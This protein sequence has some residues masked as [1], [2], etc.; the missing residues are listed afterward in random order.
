MIT[1]VRGSSSPLR[2]RSVLPRLAGAAA[3]SLTAMAALTPAAAADPVPVAP[4]RGLAIQPRTAANGPDLVLDVEG[5]TTENGAR[6]RLQRYTGADD[7]LWLA[8]PVGGELFEI[9]NVH[10]HACLDVRNNSNADEAELIQYGC[11]SGANQRWKAVAVQGGGFRI[12][13][14]GSGKCMDGY[15]TASDEPVEGAKVVQTTCASPVP[16]DQRWTFVPV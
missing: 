9:R 16:N 5:S 3:L 14:A 1:P 7:Q 13:A 12:I 2:R 8:V 10:S 6:I 15:N 11:H 4:Y